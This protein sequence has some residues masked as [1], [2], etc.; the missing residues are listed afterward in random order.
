MHQSEGQHLLKYN[1]QDNADNS[2]IA[3]EMPFL[4]DKTPA[5]AILKFDPQSKDIKVYNSK[6]GKEVSYTV[7]SRNISDTEEDG[8]NKKGWDLRRYKMVSCGD[9]YIVLDLMRKKTGKETMIKIIGLQQ[10]KDKKIKFNSISIKTEYSVEKNDSIKELNQK[11]KADK[12]FD[13]EAKYNAKKN[14]TEIKVDLVNKKE[15][16]EI[17]QGMIILVLSTEK[18][19]FKYQY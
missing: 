3:H 1:S 10:N 16:K 12:L 5:E 8:E 18:G 11:I 6:T 4:V 2:E 17:K 15:E 13:I 14:N 9:N 7:I 19:S